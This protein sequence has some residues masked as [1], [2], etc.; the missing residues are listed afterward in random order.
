M[1]RTPVLKAAVHRRLPVI[2]LAC[3]ATGTA[4][5]QARPDA[6]QTM[7][8]LQ[9]AD[10]ARQATPSSLPNLSVTP[11]ISATAAPDGA[12]IPAVKGF[13]ITGATSLP[14]VELEAL[15]EPWL[16]RELTVGEL[17]QAADRI[18]TYY[19]ERGYLVARA[20][21]PVQTLRDNI[22]EIAVLEGRLGR[23]V[24]KNSSRLSD[25]RVQAVATRIQPGESLQAPALERGLLLLQDLP[26]AGPVS[27]ALQPGEA[28]G[29][30]DLVVAVGEAPLV[31]GAIDAD[32][33]GNRFT[34]A[35]R[36]GAS[37]NL[38]SPAGLGDQL[39]VRIQASDDK[40]YYGR[41][42][43]SLPVGS[44][45]LMLGAAWSASRYQLG[46]Q[47]APLDAHG[48]ASIASVF[49]T[50]PWVRSRQ[51]NLV[52]SLAFDSKSLRDSIDVISSTSDKSLHQLRVGLGGSGQL[53]DATYSIAA[54]LTAGKLDIRSPEARLADAASARSHGNFSKIAYSLSGNLPV[55]GPWSIM[56]LMNGQFA[57]RNL[58]SSEK[59]SLGG[60]D[61][62]RAYP[63]GEA[64]GDEGYL[65]TAELRYALASE[66]PGAMYLGGF[67]D[68]GT[69]KL[70]HNPFV[71]GENKR[72]LS[73]I[74]LSF[75]WAFPDNFLLRASLARKLGKAEAISDSDQKL[76][77]WIQGVRQF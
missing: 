63:Q 56:A 72:R 57:S 42:A 40:L 50:Y 36:A 38:N 21:L 10:P 2:L 46:R 67:V 32:N 41:V 44:D 35:Y 13:R 39:G 34:G 58:D 18:T 6:G 69:I 8:E 76:R 29:S 49:A 59:F 11:G 4:L 48:R 77:F 12:R 45:G 5:A 3:A 70:N 1:L 75:N 9:R 17:K 7:H 66:W 73:A 16:G 37:L 52:G 61:G 53:A 28:V 25:D 64:V 33:H 47:F 30:S 19:R 74:G 22:V 14:T 62:V 54:A 55:A 27:A 20:Y 68:Y 51:F 26:G 71:D 24:L 31:S 65:V 15:L 60:A 43:Y 23:L